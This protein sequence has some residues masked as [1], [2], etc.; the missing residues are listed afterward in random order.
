MS[1]L[2]TFPP[3]DS[4]KHWGR[5]TQLCSFFKKIALLLFSSAPACCSSCCCCCSKIVVRK[6]KKK[7]KRKALLLQKKKKMRF[8]ISSSGA[9][10]DNSSSSSSSVSSSST[11]SFSRDD[12]RDQRLRALMEVAMGSIADGESSDDDD[13]DDNDIYA[14]AAAASSSNNNNNAN[15]GNEMDSARSFLYDLDLNQQN[16]SMTMPEPHMVD[17][18]Q[19]FNALGGPFPPRK[20]TGGGR[21]SFVTALAA[22]NSDFVVDQSVNLMDVT[23]AHVID[24]DTKKKRD[25]LRKRRHLWQLLWRDIGGDGDGGNASPYKDYDDHHTAAP[26]KKRKEC[27]L[28]FLKL[29]VIIFLLGVT[30]LAFLTMFDYLKEHANTNNRDKRIELKLEQLRLFDH[31]DNDGD[32]NSPQSMALEWIINQDPAQLDPNNVYLPQRYALAVLY[33]STGG[34][35]SWSETN[36]WMSGKGY[37]LWHGVEC[38]GEDDYIQFNGNGNVF[39]LNLTANGL[40]GTIPSELTGL[41]DLFELDL[42]SNDMLS[43]STIPTELES[44]TTLRAIVLEG[45]NLLGTIPSGLFTNIP[46]LRM[47]KLSNNKLSGSPFDLISSATNLRYLNLRN[48]NLTGQLPNLFSSLTK[49]GKLFFFFLFFYLLFFCF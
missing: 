33:Y 18:E 23:Q 17:N 1:Y 31:D 9:G 15:N 40:D 20:V 3:T 8:R 37:C 10:D 14:A 30:I 6:K 2:H 42:G 26:A 11:S 12:E 38:L 45:N 35:T 29:I 32:G 41:S 21:T 13:D 28:G 4:T 43:G 19:E 24:K 22:G 49:L 47:L 5:F 39:G 34:P 16:S 46:H 25:S 27:F 36:H 7:K 48:N 44:L